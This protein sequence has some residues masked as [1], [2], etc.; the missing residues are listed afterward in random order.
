MTIHIG[1]MKNDQ[2]RANAFARHVYANPKD[3]VICPALATSILFLPRVIIGRHL[4]HQLDTFLANLARKDL[5]SGNL[6]HWFNVRM[7]Y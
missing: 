1:K 2:E 7:L 5:K 4:R 6:R 3:L